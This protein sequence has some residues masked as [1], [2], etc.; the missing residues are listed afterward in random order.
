MFYY[1]I[2]SYRKE[3]LFEAFE[4]ITGGGKKNKNSNFIITELCLYEL[5]DSV[6]N[7]LQVKK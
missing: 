1:K 5:K 4:K 2:I 7:V 6:S 3:S